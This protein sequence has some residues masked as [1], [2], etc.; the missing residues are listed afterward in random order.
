MFLLVL[1]YDGCGSIYGPG[2]REELLE[3]VPNVA[4]YEGVEIKDILRGDDFAI[5]E[6]MDFTLQ[7]VEMKPWENMR[8]GTY[9]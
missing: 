8:A 9:Y 4:P 6:D 2:T 1:Q 3:I 5:P 7:L